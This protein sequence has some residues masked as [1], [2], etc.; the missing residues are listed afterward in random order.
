MRN[1]RKLPLLVTRRSRL[2]RGSSIGSRRSRISTSN[3]G[4]LGLGTIAS[5]G[6]SPESALS[7]VMHHSSARSSVTD[8]RYKKRCWRAAVVVAIIAVASTANSADAPPLLSP[9]QM[10]G[11]EIQLALQKLNVLGRVLYIAAHPD[12]ENTNLMAFW[13]N[14]SLYDAAYLSVTRGDGGQNLIGPELGERLGVIRTE[15]L[16]DARRIDHARQFFTRA[17]DFGFSKTA[18]ETLRIWGHDKILADIVWVIRNFQPDVI[19]T[20]FSPEDQKTHGHHTASAIL[21][22][23][24]FSAAADP[25]RFP[26]QLAFVKPWQATRLVWNT[27]PFFFTNRNLPFDPT[28]LMAMEA[29]GY[30]PLL[31]KAYTEIAAASISM[32]KSQGVGG[33]PRRGARKEYFKPL[34]GQPMTNSLFEGV[35]TTWSRVANSES[36]AAQIRQIISK[37]NPADPA[38]SVPEL[39]KL[40]QTMSGIQDDSWIAEKKAQLQDHRCVSGL[41]CGSVDSNGN[42]YTWPNRKNKTRGN[43]SLERSGHTA[44]SAIP[45]H[46]RFKQGRCGASIERARYEGSVLQDSRQCSVFAA[47]LASQTRDARNLHR[48]RSKA[49]RFSRESPCSSDR[50][51]FTSQRAGTAVQRGY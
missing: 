48:R 12:D 50:G 30:N 19:V 28:G 26:E 21:A 33:P 38:A 36:V 51:S 34:K 35:D 7:R 1:R 20:R 10:N 17:I 4:Y 22:Q 42:V 40:R 46:W 44:R 32:H 25:N 37:F 5:M 41:A 27:S 11:S 15:E 2:L 8:R 16:L 31:G 9:D 23:E 14:G 43:Q 47:I 49:Y 3:A 45:E 39:L 24:A 18:D 6:R 29:G 13:A